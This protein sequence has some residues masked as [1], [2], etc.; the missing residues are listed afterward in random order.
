MPCFDSNGH[1]RFSIAIAST[2]KRLPPS[3]DKACVPKLQAAARE[4]ADALGLLGPERTAQDA[5]GYAKIAAGYSLSPRERQ[6]ALQRT[7]L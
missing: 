1:V 4:M 7:P 5:A 6:P 2:R 3:R